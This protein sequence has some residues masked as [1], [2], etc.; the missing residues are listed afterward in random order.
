M[1]TTQTLSPSRFNIISHSSYTCMQDLLPYLVLSDFP[2][3]NESHCPAPQDVSVRREQLPRNDAKRLSLNSELLWFGGRR[4]RHPFTVGSRKEITPKDLERNLDEELGL[5]LCSRQI[6]F[7]FGPPFFL[8]PFCLFRPM[9]F[10]TR[11]AWVTGTMR[12]LLK[13]A[14]W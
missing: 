2:R 11:C 6:K 7:S 14:G 8:L 9:P 10:T 13:G 12:Q 5:C 4:V 3:K 1:P